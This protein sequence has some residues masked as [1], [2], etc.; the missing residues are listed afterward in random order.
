MLENYLNY[1]EESEDKGIKMLLGGKLD[2]AEK[3]FSGLVKKDNYLGYYGIATI[4][5]KGDNMNPNQEKTGEIVDFYKR[6]ISLNP[7]FA[8]A[9]FMCGLAYEQLASV[10]VS[11]YKKDPLKESDKK[12]KKIKQVLRLAKEMI[13]NA[14]KL[15]PSFKKAAESEL[16]SYKTR[17]NGMDSLRKFFTQNSN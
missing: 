17:L 10:L 7:N 4:R 8:D 1:M 6:A 3:Y 13:E 16:S 15:K 11:E 9:Y 12:V 5:F 2:E 14:V